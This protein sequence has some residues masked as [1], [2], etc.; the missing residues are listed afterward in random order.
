[1]IKKEINRISEVGKALISVEGNP[2][3]ALNHVVELLDADTNQSLSFAKAINIS[4]NSTRFQVFNGTGGLSTK[5]KLR[6]HEVPL[7]AGFSY[8]MLGR[9]FDGIGQVADNGPEVIFE[10]QLETSL[11]TLNP[12]VRLVPKQPLWTGIPMIDVFNTLVKSQKI[13][14]FASPTEP[15][16]R[17]LSQIA[18]GAQA[19]V[20]IFAGI[21]LKFDEYHYFK[22]QLSQSGNIDKTIMF[23][24]LAGES[25][26]KGLMLPD[27]ALSVAREF[28]DQ[29]KDALVLLTDMT[30]WS[31]ILRNVA[32][33]QDMIPSLQGYPGSLYSELARRY[34]VAADIEG[35]GSIT[36]IGATTLES[37]EDP[38]PDNTGYITEGQFFLENGKLKLARSLSRLKQ[39]VNGNTRSDHRP[40]M[41]AMAS[42]LA[43]AEKA[44]EAAEVGAANDAFS[45]K[46][47]AYRSDFI[48]N[49]E[50]P[51]G[52]PLELDAALDR[53]WEILK[54]HFEPTETGLSKKL[55]EE[56]W[57]N[58]N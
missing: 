34:E 51:F 16:N 53:C 28:A 18:M 58:Q 54:R 50:E 2:G 42:L 25:Q 46:L 6:M 3:V 21:G 43:D 57:D 17:L 27:V 29:G 19:D 26:I 41:T 35:A 48:A 23:V 13:P 15:Y 22:D 33:Y 47:L 36:I 9:T 56:Y 40:I 32:N 45:Q 31:N 37:L 11:D 49:M 1:M 44:Y 30:N 14:I 38:V 39:Q 4:E 7:T 8:N 5:T 55:I 24:H 10:K 20:I 52:D 12:T